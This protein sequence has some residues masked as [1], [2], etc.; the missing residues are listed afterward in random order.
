NVFTG[1]PPDA[2]VIV[3]GFGSQSQ[4]WWTRGIESMIEQS[5]LIFVAGIGNGYEVYDPPLYPAAGTNVIG[6]GVVDS[7]NSNDMAINLA[8]FSLAYPDHS[9]FGPTRDGRC[10]PDIIACGNCLAANING[11]NN[12]E[13]TGNWSSFSTPT[14]AGTIGL[15]V[16]KA[17]QDPNVSSVI[18]SH[19]GNCVIKA[20]L[21]NSATKLPYWHKGRVDI[22]DDHQVPLDYIQGAGM[23]NAVSAYEHLIA[24]QAKADEVS[25]IGWDLN[26]LDKDKGPKNTYRISVTEPV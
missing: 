12:Y 17:K 5:G 18:S 13:P 8:H 25:G 24:G 26:H 15:L 6:V 23:L 20:I 9:S 19:S 16:Q 22:D 11:P 1:S 4:D 10:K 14:V 2:D 7:V 21:M 3:A